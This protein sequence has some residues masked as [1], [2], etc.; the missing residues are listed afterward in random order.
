VPEGKPLRPVFFGRPNA[1]DWVMTHPDMERARLV[2]CLKDKKARKLYP[3]LEQVRAMHPKLK[4]A[5]RQYLIRQAKIYNGDFFMWPVPWFDGDDAP[6]DQTQR[7]AHFAAK[8][9]WIRLEWR[10]GDYEI[11]PT[12]EPHAFDPPDW[13]AAEDFDE[14]MNRA[15]TSILVRDLDHRYVKIYLGRR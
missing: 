7:D 14:A 5:A 10:G 6:G 4:G 8:D 3:I 2:Y 12:E 11:I 15:V 13:R 1:S 9:D